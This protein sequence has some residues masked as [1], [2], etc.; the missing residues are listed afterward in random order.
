MVSVFRIDRERS[1]QQLR[2]RPSMGSASAGRSA[3]GACC[4]FHEAC[5]LFGGRQR[6][7]RAIAGR[8]QRR[9]GARPSRRGERHRRRPPGVRETSRR[10]SRR[11]RW[12]RRHRPETRR[13]GVRR[14][15]SDTSEPSR[16]SFKTTVRAPCRWHQSTIDAG[17]SSP[18]TSA[19][20]I[21][22]RQKV[23]GRA[24]S[25]PI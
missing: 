19:H 11:R 20:V 24:E 3:H 25:S 7:D 5:H 9:R 23:V 22:A 10:S 17:S 4:R 8:R 21:Q 2:L 1:M 6:R 16:P 12:H 18:E 14:S 13:I 15:P